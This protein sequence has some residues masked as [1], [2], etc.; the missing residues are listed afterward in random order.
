MS[1]FKHH[2]ELA[3]VPRPLVDEVVRALLDWME[4][5]PF[6]D[7]K[8]DIGEDFDGDADVRLTEGEHLTTGARYRIE[9]LG[10]DDE[11]LTLDVK[12]VSW[13]RAGES[14]IEITS[15]LEGHVVNAQI[16][17]RMAGQRAHT[18]RVEGDYQGPG[19]GLLR[20]L[21]RAKWEGEVRFEEWWSVLGQRTSP[22]SLRVQHP[23][24]FAS[25]RGDRGK[26]VDERWSVESI[27]RFRG[28][29]VARPV[30]ALG[31]LIMRGR[32]RRLLRMSFEKAETAWNDAVPGMAERGWQE[33]VTVRHQVEVRSVSRKWVE[34][35]VAALHRHIGELRVENGRLTDTTADIR[36]LEGEHI[37][38]GARYRIALEENSETQHNETKEH[39][40]T[41]R[42]EIGKHR[43][44]E[45]L[46]ISVTAWEPDGPSRIE[47][48]GPENAQTG[49]AELDSAAKPTRVRAAFDG[50]F[51]EITRLK[52]TAEGDLERWWAGVDGSG[53]DSPAFTAKVEQPLGEGIFSIAG[54]PGEDGRWKLDVSFTAEGRG[55]ARPLI[56][57][58][59][60]LSGNAVQETF[61]S[62]TDEAATDWDDTISKA[63]EAG[64]DL[65]AKT[66]LHRLL[67]E[68]ATTTKPD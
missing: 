27:L 55:W 49:W 14:R 24:A 32:V 42:N 34:D 10:G 65:A 4:G 15:D 9:L 25:F 66:T 52:V 13:D 64:P 48:N 50:A 5:L 23:L 59:G 28:R 29:W 67:N 44:T 30:A 62:T 58:A 56:A 7:G 45:S 54:S 21:Q 39:S 12:L 60:L 57:L 20:R 1:R 37:R 2:A 17:L 68:P 61:A 36:L 63:I 6:T 16:E 3:P 33:R 19:P 46:D 41:Q 43:R 11:Q 47:M 40:E 53:D 38:P 22:I 31:L 26:D 51:E 8:L 35:Y 18:F